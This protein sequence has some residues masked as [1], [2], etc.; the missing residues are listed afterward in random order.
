MEVLNIADVGTRYIVPVYG[1]RLIAE[2]QS[3]QN[4]MEIL[5]P[6]WLYHHETTQSVNANS[7]LFKAVLEHFLSTH[8]IKVKLRPSRSSSKNGHVKR[9]NGVFKMVLSRLA[10][11]SKSALHSNLVSM[12][13]FMT[14][15]FH[16]IAAL[17]LIFR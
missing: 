5:E 2:N 14:N 10:T 1:K 8:K 7:E 3:A 12:A 6:K 11:E 4:I 13:S 15:L 17:F 9:N 16:E